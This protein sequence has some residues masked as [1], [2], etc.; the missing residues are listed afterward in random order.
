MSYCTMTKDQYRHAWLDTR[1][2]IDSLIMKTCDYYNIL[3]EIEWKGSSTVLMCPMCQCYKA[4]GHS[5]DCELGS[6]IWREENES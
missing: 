3:K 1:E 6:M 4:M 5:K 2:E